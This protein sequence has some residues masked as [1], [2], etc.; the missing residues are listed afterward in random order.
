[1]LDSKLQCCSWI[2]HH[3]MC[4]VQAPLR[5]NF[6]LQKDRK[7]LEPPFSCCDLIILINLLWEKSQKKWNNI[8]YSLNVC[9]AETSILKLQTPGTMIHLSCVCE[10][11]FPNRWKPPW[12]GVGAFKLRGFNKKRQQGELNWAPQLQPS[13]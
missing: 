9:P 13:G 5:G 10:S 6:Q 2:I 4:H 11:K 7:Y 3:K 1:M 8:K 12:R